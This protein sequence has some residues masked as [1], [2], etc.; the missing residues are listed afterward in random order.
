MGPPEVLMMK[1]VVSSNIPHTN[2]RM[3]PAAFCNA[4]PIFHYGPVIGKGSP[5]SGPIGPLTP[6]LGALL[7]IMHISRDGSGIEWRGDECRITITALWL[8][9]AL[10]AV[11]PTR[12]PVNIIRTT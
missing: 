10:N 12:Y 2:P 6:S 11:N 5:L 4:S 1:R 8:N 7:G 3:P 9:K